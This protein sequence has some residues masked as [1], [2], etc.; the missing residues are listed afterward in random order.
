MRSPDPVPPRAKEQKMA[1]TT[2]ADYVVVSDGPV[3]DPPPFKVSKD[4]TKET[5]SVITYVVTSVTPGFTFKMFINGMALESGTVKVDQ[6]PCALQ[7][8]IDVGVLVPS[9][10]T[11]KLD[12]SVTNGSGIFRDIVLLYQHTV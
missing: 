10:G 7:E 6:G 4:L 1:T 2:V 12:I 9:P 11:N 3:I 5:R 8:V